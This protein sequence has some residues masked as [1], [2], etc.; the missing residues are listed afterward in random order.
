MVA[1]YRNLGIVYAR[2]RDHGADR[3][4]SVGHIGVQFIAAPV[5]LMTLAARLHSD[6]TVARQFLQH[7]FQW[8]A[9]L[10]VQSRVGAGGP[11]W[12]LPALP[13]FMWP[14]FL[15]LFALAGPFRGC[16]LC[17]LLFG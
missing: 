5:L 17:L 8:H 10:P 3:N 11:P 6:R 14:G 9:A 2:A 12:R 4:L 7:F 1:R 15:P 13:S 16:D